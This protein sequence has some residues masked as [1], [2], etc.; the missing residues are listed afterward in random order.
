MSQLKILQYNTHLFGGSNAK[1]INLFKKV[2]YQ[3]EKRRQELI[4]SILHIDADIV[5]LN[6]VWAEDWKK[7]IAE[8]VRHQYPFSWYPDENLPIGKFIGSG[9]MILSKHLLDGA[10]FT[11]FNELAD[12]DQFAQKG[13][14]SIKAMIQDGPK[15]YDPHYIILTHLQAPTKHSDAPRRSNLSQ[16]AEGLRSLGYG[17]HPVMLIGDL[18][19]Y[20]D[21]SSDASLYQNLLRTFKVY[22]FSDVFRAVF[23][24][25]KQTPG[26]TFDATRNNLVGVFEPDSKSRHRLDYC[27]AKVPD[28]TKW[29][30]EIL[31]D[32]K[33]QD[34]ETKGVRDISDHFPLL[35]TVNI[36][37]L[38]AEL[39]E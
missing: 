37:N 31:Y 10:K 7:H 25:S 33:Y 16:I 35:L 12:E 26:F 20:G 9:L 22:K 29:N 21:Q 19:I 27:I 14:I 4:K 2:L 6:E 3:D 39:N 8:A 15:H 1:W 38:G 28:G 18:N 34:T 11:P 13:F 17:R 24:D 32:L 5:T 30:V 23:P 36:P